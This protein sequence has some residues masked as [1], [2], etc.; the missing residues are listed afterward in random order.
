MARELWR[1]LNLDEFWSGKL[2]RSRAS[3]DWAALLEVSVAYRL[4]APGSE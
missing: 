4:I 1:T 3:T 2:G